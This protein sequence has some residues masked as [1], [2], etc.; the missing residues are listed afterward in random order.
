MNAPIAFDRLTLLA[1]AT[2]EAGAASD[3]ACVAPTVRA[4][5]CELSARHESAFIDRAPIGRTC[6]HDETGPFH[7]A[8]VRRPRPASG[9]AALGTR[10]AGR[11]RGRQ[12][13]C[14]QGSRSDCKSLSDCCSGVADGIEF[15]EKNGVGLVIGNQAGGMPGAFSAGGDLRWLRSLRDNSVHANAD[16]MRQFYQSFLCLRRELPVPVIAALHGPAMGAGAGLALACDL[17]TAA[18]RDKILGLH[19]SRLGIHTGE[20]MR[21]GTDLLGLTVNKAAR[22]AS[23]AAEGQIVISSTTCDLVGSMEGF[24]AG[25]PKAVMLKGI[26]GTHHVVPITW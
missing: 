26:S 23:A 11:H 16:L 25:E 5:A 6:P 7:L 22:V 24:V 12:G 20:V 17:R 19:F 21:T 10:R 3:E 9:G 13:Q 15:V 4:R 18:P 14:C 8:R 2:V 1:R